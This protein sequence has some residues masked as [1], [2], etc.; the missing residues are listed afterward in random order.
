[1]GSPGEIRLLL[2]PKQVEV[3]YVPTDY[4][5]AGLDGTWDADNDGCVRREGICNSVVEE[6]DWSANVYV[7]RMPAR[8]VPT[9]QAIVQKTVNYQ[10]RQPEIC[11]FGADIS[12]S[13]GMARY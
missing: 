12:S 11:L 6:A 2:I 13:V 7:G 4:Y 5:Y 1:M 3:N 10:P 9:M 8:D